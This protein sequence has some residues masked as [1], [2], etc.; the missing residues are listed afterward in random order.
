MNLEE[1]L[2]TNKK[3]PFVNVDKIKKI[4]KDDIILCT[5]CDG[6][7]SQCGNKNSHIIICDLCSGSGRLRKVKYLVI[8]KPKSWFF[9]VCYYIIRKFNVK[10]RTSNE[11]KIYLWE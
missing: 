6:E 1:L 7:G 5:S 8:D 4:I 9:K 10:F 2:S 11:E 3:K